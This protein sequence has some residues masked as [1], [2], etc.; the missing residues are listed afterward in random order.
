MTWSPTSDGSSRTPWKVGASDSFGFGPWNTRTRRCTHG[1]VRRGERADP[2]G[3]LRAVLDPLARRRAGCERLRT[4][5]DR[6]RRRDLPALPAPP[7]GE[8][9]RLG[10]HAARRVGRGC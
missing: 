3:P 7:G 6:G 1:P 10:A 9:G 8:P 2:D 5:A 4:V